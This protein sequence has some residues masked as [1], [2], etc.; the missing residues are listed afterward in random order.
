MYKEYWGGG[1]DQGGL[2]R[3]SMLEEGIAIKAVLGSTSASRI[4]QKL[5]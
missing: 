3:R 1:W 4:Q 5:N 2:T